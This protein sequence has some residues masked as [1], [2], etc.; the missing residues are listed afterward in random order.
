MGWSARYNVTQTCPSELTDTDQ[1]QVQLQN[2]LS[3]TEPRY[4]VQT[5][6]HLIGTCLKP[7]IKPYT[8]LLLRKKNSIPA[9]NLMH[10]FIN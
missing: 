4:K 1:C 8:K 9:G 5:E 7:I 10:S 6:A 3:K 2:T